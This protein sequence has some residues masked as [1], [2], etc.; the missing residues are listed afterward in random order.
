MKRIGIAVVL[1]AALFLLAGGNVHALMPFQPVSNIVSVSPSTPSA[2]GDLTYRISVPAEHHLVTRSKLH[3]PDA[4]EISRDSAVT[5]LAIVGTG[6]LLVHPL[7]DSVCGPTANTYPMTI[8][9]VGKQPGDPSNVKTNWLLQ[10]YPVRWFNLVVEDNGAAG[11]HIDH[12]LFFTAGPACSPME[13]TL[14][15]FGVSRDNPAEGVS[16]GDTVLTNPSTAAVY[17]FDNELLSAPLSFPPDPNPSHVVT[18]CD[19]VRV[20]SGGSIDGDGD[21]IADVC[22]NCPSDP[23]PDQ[24]DT[25]EDGLADACDPDIDD[26]SQGLGDVFGLFLRNDV[27]T[28]LGTMPAVACPATDAT[29]DEHPDAWGPDFDDSRDVDGSDVFLFALRFG[30]QKDVPPS[31]GKQP[32]IERFDIYPTAASLSKIDAPDVFVIASYFGRS[33][34]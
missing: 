29:N 24:L 11:H 10:G 19:A 20:G 14:T 15:I 12:Q 31:V 5:D 33:C 2:N 22:D 34:P 18:V 8:L 23:N 32:Y 17:T 30:T 16:G 21:G 25:D 4:W 9:E 3:L 28:F 26:D 27:E 1:T 7:I 6:T 13:L